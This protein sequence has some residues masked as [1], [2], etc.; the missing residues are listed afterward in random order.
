MIGPEQKDGFPG[1]EPTRMVR[2]TCQYAYQDCPVTSEATLIEEKEVCNT[3][4]ECA[5]E[6]EKGGCPA[7]SESASE[8]EEETS[9]SELGSEVSKPL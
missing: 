1:I 2:E 8:P 5:S 9:T 6:P 7:P 3:I 4:S